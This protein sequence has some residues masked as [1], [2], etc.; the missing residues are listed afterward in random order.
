MKSPGCCW[1]PAERSRKLPARSGLPTC[2]TSPAI[3]ARAKKRVRSS[4]EKLTVVRLCLDCRKMVFF[5]RKMALSLC[6]ALTYLL[7][8]KHVTDI[9]TGHVSFKH[10][11][12]SFAVFCKVIKAFFVDRKRV[13]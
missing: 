3:F 4:S 1:R 6:P 10:C 9:E 12:R 13:V 11:V 5:F 8:I 7:I 2:N